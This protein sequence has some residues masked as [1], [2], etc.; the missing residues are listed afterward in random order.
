MRFLTFISISHMFS[1]EE[2]FSKSLQQRDKSGPFL[3]SSRFRKQTQT[4]F[5]LYFIVC[6]CLSGDINPSRALSVSS[7][8]RFLPHNLAKKVY[9]PPLFAWGDIEK[10]FR[11]RRRH[12]MRFCLSCFFGRE[13]GRKALSRDIPKI[14]N[15]NGKTEAFNLKF[16]KDSV[17]FINTCLEPEDH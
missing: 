10:S 11:W 9:F 5:S 6:L 7:F 1:L 8:R 17:T 13:N 15:A 3:F 16:Q 12:W 2:I 14:S 4:V